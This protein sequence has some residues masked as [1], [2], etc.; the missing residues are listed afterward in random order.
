MPLFLADTGLTGVG[1]EVIQR[2]GMSGDVKHLQHLT[3][4]L[5]RESAAAQGVAT[6]E[7]VDRLVLETAAF[8]DRVDTVVST[9]QIVQS[10]GRAR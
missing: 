10:W 9:P 5:I 4:A 8:A 7:E 6:F 1:V 2:A 3:L